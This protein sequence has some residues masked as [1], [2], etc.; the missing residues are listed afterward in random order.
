MLIPLTLSQTAKTFAEFDLS[1]LGFS[2]QY[3]DDSVRALQ[4]ADELSLTQEPIY[5]VWFDRG[6]KDGEAEISKAATLAG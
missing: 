1:R 4:A 6:L 3:V 2:G 5:R